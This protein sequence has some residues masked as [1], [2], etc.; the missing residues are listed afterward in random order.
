MGELG[1][2]R[3]QGPK[4]TG[5]SA[6]LLAVAFFAVLGGVCWSGYVAWHEPAPVRTEGSAVELI[7]TRDPALYKWLPVIAASASLAIA[8]LQRIAGSNPIRFLAA[9]AGLVA[10][11]GITAGIEHL[12]R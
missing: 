8:A 4:R 10:L 2:S 11:Q 3:N 1:I 7:V 5:L 6:T 12:M 9:A